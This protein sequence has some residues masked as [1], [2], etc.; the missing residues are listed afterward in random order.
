MSEA[1]APPVKIQAALLVT[2]GK[3]GS[4]VGWGWGAGGW[5]PWKVPM[6]HNGLLAEHI[7][8]EKAEQ[9]QEER[10]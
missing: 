5:E 7:S 8:E 2:G 4:D 6:N 1:T 9:K 3:T 10:Q